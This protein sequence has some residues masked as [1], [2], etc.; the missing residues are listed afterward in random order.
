MAV[1]Q[2]LT[3]LNA[4]RERATPISGKLPSSFVF[5]SDIDRVCAV[6]VDAARLS[7]AELALAYA[8]PLLDDRD[9]WLAL[10]RGAEFPT[11]RRAAWLRPKV[12]VW[13]VDAADDLQEHALPARSEELE[14]WRNVAVRV[15]AVGLGERAEWVTPLLEWARSAPRVI[16]TSRETYVDFQCDGRSILKI[17][18][19][20]S[21]LEIRAGTDWS[22]PGPDRPEPIT[23]TLD[24]PLSPADAHRLVAH[25]AGAAV[26]RL[27]E[28]DVANAEHRL[29][30]RLLAKDLGLSDWRR[31]M[32]AVRPAPGESG[33][34][35]RGKRAYLDFLGLGSGST[36][37]VVETKIGPD[38]ML[39]LQGLDYWTWAM[40]QRDR[41]AVVFALGTTTPQI[42]IDYVVAQKGPGKPFVGALTRAQAEAL[43][44]EI[45]WR[46]HTVENDGDLRPVV[47]ACPPRTV[48]VV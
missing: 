1:D 9:L 34:F 32:P 30:A 39:V 38:P 6:A 22:S 21:S 8:L 41:L 26:A 18:P 17:T 2:V 19:V 24:Q 44:G 5:T 3:R 12:R 35:K 31:E 37:H 27:T 13:T 4:P 10:P 42:A 28:I 33:P 47:K 40:S 43:D 15:G 36:L 16:D 7:D 29:Q 23:M 20:G 14:R 46:F 45:F 25:A 48:P 11:L